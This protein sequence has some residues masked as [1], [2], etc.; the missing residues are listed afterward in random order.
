MVV[1]KVA[2]E[3]NNC[4]VEDEKRQPSREKY[5]CVALVGVDG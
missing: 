2:E 1:S 3:Q 5:Y 4:S